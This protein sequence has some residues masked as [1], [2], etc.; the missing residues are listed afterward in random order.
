MRS[1]YWKN[2]RALKWGL[3]SFLLEI[4]FLPIIIFCLYYYVI[5]QLI[6]NG[7]ILKIDFSNKYI[8]ILTYMSWFLFAGLSI[9]L[10]NTS[11]S[12]KEED[13]IWKKYKWFICKFWWV[14][15]INTQDEEKVSI[16]IK[17]WV[18]K[19]KFSLLLDVLTLV[20]ISIVCLLLSIFSSFRLDLIIKYLFLVSI[21]QLLSLLGRMVSY[22]KIIG[23][24][25]K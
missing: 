20:L 7:I 5:F 12:Q 1:F 2:S 16:G 23:F 6:N 8:E 10:S 14:D 21:T 19:L 24:N 18:T 13:S 25:I 4:L 3:W 11:F 17:T 9:L 22:L 15:N